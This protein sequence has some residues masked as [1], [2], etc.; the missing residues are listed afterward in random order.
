MLQ[1]SGLTPTEQ[2]RIESLDNPLSAVFINAGKTVGICEAV[3]SVGGRVF[4]FSGAKGIVSTVDASEFLAAS[5]E[6]AI[7]MVTSTLQP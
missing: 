1:C 6:A 5:D 4:V 7:D 2:N 3:D